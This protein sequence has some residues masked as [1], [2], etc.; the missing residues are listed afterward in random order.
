VNAP[1]QAPP[2][3]APTKE[4]QSALS[5]AVEQAAKTVTEGCAAM[6]GV[7]IQQADRLSSGHYGLDDLVAGQFAVLRTW[8]K[9]ATFGAETAVNNVALLAWPPATP[10]EAD[11]A[12]IRKLEVAVTF[13][14]A[15]VTSS[16]LLGHYCGGC[17]PSAAVVVTT[18]P[19]DP[20]HVVTVT[21]NFGDQANDIYDGTLR[22]A[23]GTAST[24][25]AVPF[26]E[27]GTSGSAPRVTHY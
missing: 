17:V 27:F 12:R 8:V 1:Q 16:D 5:E 7:A 23:D 20:G 25:F 21:V 4:R 3:P 10:G 18:P 22:S 2:G 19:G 13:A 26:S 15:G 6:A 24:P 11:P 9:Y 14:P